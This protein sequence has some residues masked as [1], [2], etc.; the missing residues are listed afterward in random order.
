VMSLEGFYRGSERV[1]PYKPYEADA[2]VKLDANENLFLPKEFIQN[3][4]VEAAR[5]CDPRLYPQDETSIL[6][7]ALAEV[8]AV[9][10]GQLVVASGGDQVIELLVSSMLREGD[11]VVAVSPTF[12]MYPRFAAIRRLRYRPVELDPGFALDPAKVLDAVSPETGMI[13]LCNPNNPTGNQFKVEAV[14]ELVEGFSGLVLIDEAY[15]EYGEHSL[16]GE[17]AERENLV[18]LRTFSKAYGLAGM[19]LGYAVT[20]TRL[21]QVLN[22][23]YLPPFPVSSLTLW[24]GINVLRNRDKVEAAVRETKEERKRLIEALNGLPGVQAFPSATNFVLFNTEKPYTEV[25]DGLSR[26]GV[27][28]RRIGKIPG[29]DDCLRVTVA[30]R[31]EATEF[32]CALEEA[33]T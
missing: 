5:S 12:S 11:E 18:V 19:R 16:A 17:A 13:V 27:H 15:A 23:R 25:Y 24:A 6:K 33:T 1:N 3:M 31:E 26:R 14:L 29:Y 4:I 2:V 21:A 20:N 7:M 8:L 22:E 30:P 32:L 10:P 28:V 9:Q